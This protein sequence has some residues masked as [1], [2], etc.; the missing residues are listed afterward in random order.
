MAFK[1][2]MAEPEA[3]GFSEAQLQAIAGVVQGL[4]D[5]ALKDVGA[6]TT[7]GTGVEGDGKSQ[8]S[9]GDETT[10]EPGHGEAGT[11]P[12]NHGDRKA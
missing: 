3:T 1:R 9:R 11:P 6:R 7:A 8:G 2:E 12:R 4:L 10:G 5:R